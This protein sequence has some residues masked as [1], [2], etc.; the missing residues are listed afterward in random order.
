MIYEL[1]NS[2]MRYPDEGQMDAT[3]SVFRLDREWVATREST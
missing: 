2:L 3:W 1:R